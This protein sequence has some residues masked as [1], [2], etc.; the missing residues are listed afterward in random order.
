MKFANKF[1][2]FLEEK[3]EFLY[4]V[5]K[6]KDVNLLGWGPS[7]MAAYNYKTLEEAKQMAQRIAN[8]KGYNLL[9][10]ELH[11]SDTKIGLA[12]PVKI[13]PRPNLGLN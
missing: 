3:E 1:V 7:P 9:V 10:C 6:G 8:N 4:S 12:H 5:K 11:E 2:I 13:S